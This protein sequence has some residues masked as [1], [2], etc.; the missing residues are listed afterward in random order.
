MRSEYN[1]RWKNRLL[2]DTQFAIERVA[3]QV[4]DVIDVIMNDPD[5]TQDRDSIVR[6]LCT[7]FLYDANVHDLD[8]CPL[9]QS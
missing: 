3:V 1:R 4:D 8:G 5:T 9:C 6:M 7:Y 2:E